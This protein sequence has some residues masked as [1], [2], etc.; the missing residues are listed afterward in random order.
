MEAS[1][2]VRSAIV[3]GGLIGSLAIVFEGASALA[4]SAE[5]NY[6]LYCVQCHG[7]LG[8]GEGINQTAGG[9]TVSP[10]NHTYAKHMSELGDDELRLAI[11]E[12]GDAVQKSDLMPPW[13]KTLSAEEIDELVHHL[14]TLCKCEGPKVGP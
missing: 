5:E 12:G 7:T 6:R 2:M 11:A 4:G 1:E 3:L 8:N 13:G 14:R 9:L 10:R